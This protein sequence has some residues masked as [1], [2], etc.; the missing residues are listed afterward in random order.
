M[1]FHRPD[2]PNFKPPKAERGTKS[3]KAHMARVAKLPCVI[4]GCRPV[5]VHHVF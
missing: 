2:T 1:T 3:A 4:C 5:E